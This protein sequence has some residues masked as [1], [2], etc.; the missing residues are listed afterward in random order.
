MI[1]RYCHLLKISG[2][3]GNEWRSWLAP[4]KLQR[5]WVRNEYYAL[6]A[7]YTEWILPLVT[8]LPSGEM[9]LKLIKKPDNILRGSLQKRRISRMW[10]TLKFW[11]H[12]IHPTFF[13]NS[14]KLLG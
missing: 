14:K 11:R 5:N 8:R 7:I 1:Y 12:T 10:M 9:I 13:M 4:Y 6:I 3:R 2:L